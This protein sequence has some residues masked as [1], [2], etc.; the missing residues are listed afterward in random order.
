MRRGRIELGIHG[1]RDGWEVA[2]A[3]VP[4]RA[5]GFHLVAEDQGAIRPRPGETPPPGVRVGDDYGQ[6]AV[7]MA[8]EPEAPVF[9]PS[10]LAMLE[11][12]PTTLLV[13][14]TGEADLLA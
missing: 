5:L 4:Q 2:E 9:P 1:V 10:Y 7:W 8:E 3:V 12:M 6:G 13:S 14:S 11:D